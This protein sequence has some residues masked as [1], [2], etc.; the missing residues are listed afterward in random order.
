MEEQYVF[1]FL[2][3]GMGRYKGGGRTRTGKWVGLGY[4]MSSSQR[5]I[6]FNYV[7]KNAPSFSIF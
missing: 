1:S 3:V 2:G 6:F 5:I 7:K 4:T